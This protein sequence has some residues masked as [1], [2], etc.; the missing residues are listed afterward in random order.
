MVT[1]IATPTL[2]LFILFACGFSYH[3]SLQRVEET[4]AKS[5]QRV[6]HIQRT[7]WSI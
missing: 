1:N 2:L 4:T 3:D 6:L 7:A 5:T